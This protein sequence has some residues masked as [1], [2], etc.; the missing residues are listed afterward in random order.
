MALGRDGSDAG[1]HGSGTWCGGG[2]GGRGCATVSTSRRHCGEV[3]DG[4]GR[5]GPEVRGREES[6]ETRGGSS[7]E[8]LV[9]SVVLP[10][11]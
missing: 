9:Y 11:A 7:E 8:S 5:H 4:D 10:G 1:D 6:G 3:G 2:G